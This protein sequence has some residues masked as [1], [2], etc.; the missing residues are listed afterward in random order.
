MQR[1]KNE[2]SRLKSELEERDKYF[3]K[4]RERFEDIHMKNFKELEDERNAVS[5]EL[6]S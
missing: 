2:I 5:M 6:K 3:A 4:E 1:L